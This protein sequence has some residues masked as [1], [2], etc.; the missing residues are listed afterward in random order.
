MLLSDLVTHKKDFLSSDVSLFDAIE[1]MGKE[2]ISHIVLIE[3]NVAVGVLT[4]RDI[5]GLY[6]NG[7]EGEKKAID[8]ATYPT[9]SIHDDRPVEMAVELMIDYE[10]RRLVLIDENGKYLCTLTQ[11][12]VLTYY[13][14]EVHTAQEVFQCLNR[15]NCAITVDQLLMRVLIVIRTMMRVCMML[16]V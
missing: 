1:R 9:I 2:G 16:L 12:D 4:L 13:E 11:S 3:N 6:R 7:I 10:I 8:Y 15:R 5:I 14:S